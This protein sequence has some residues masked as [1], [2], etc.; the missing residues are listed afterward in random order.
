LVC[1]S[2]KGLLRVG[3]EDRRVEI[4]ANRVTATGEPLNYIN[5]LDVAPDGTVY[6]SSST[7]ESVALNDQGFYDTMRSYMLNSVSG[8]STGQLLSWDPKTREVTPLL[9]GIGFANGVAVSADGSFVAVV[10]THLCRVWRYWLQGPRKGTSDIFIDKLPGFP[11]GM[12]RSAAGGFWVPLVVPVTPLLKHMGP[13]RWVRQLLS[14]FV[15]RLLP[16]AAKR[17]GCVVR[18]DGDGRP[19]ETLM[20]PKGEVVSTVSAVTEAADGRLFLGNLGGSGVSWVAP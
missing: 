10:E 6:F 13:H 18:L 15:L 5:D 8:G 20:D 3:L 19:V 1:D 7:A 17:W 4:L 12:T 9:G 2:L 11:D 16:Y 14:H